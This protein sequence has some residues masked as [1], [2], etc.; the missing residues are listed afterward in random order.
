[1]EKNNSFKFLLFGLV[2]LFIAIS[3]FVLMKKSQNFNTYSN[4]NVNKTDN[5]TVDIRKDKKKDYFYYEENNRITADL[6]VEYKIIVFNFN[7][8]NNIAKIL[9]DETEE[10]K[11]TVTYTEKEIAEDEFDNLESAKYKTYESFVYDKYL[12]LLVNYYSFNR[13]TLITFEKSVAY[14]FSKDS[15]K[16]I[17]KDELLEYYKLS[18]EDV[19]KKV[20]DYIEGVSKLTDEVVIDIEGTM[21][22]LD[23]S[24]IYVDK[25]GRLTISILV[26][27]DQSDYNDVVVL[28]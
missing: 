3:G 11:K 21:N 5:E 16:E 28:S 20:R 6:D 2:V 9:N 26:K 7:D 1:M 27:N 24:A 23:K 22:N 25:V 13:E 10:L 18:S 8:E 19:N 17:T 14:I 12:S 15:G 4:D